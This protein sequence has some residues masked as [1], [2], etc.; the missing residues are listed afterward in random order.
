[1]PSSTAGYRGAL[2]AAPVLGDDRGS[3][4]L[5]DPFPSTAAGDAAVKREDGILRAV[6]ALMSLLGGPLVSYGL[7]KIAS[8]A[9]VSLST[10][11]FIWPLILFTPS[12]LGLLGCVAVLNEGNARRRVVIVG[13]ALIVVAMVPLYFMAILAGA[14]MGPG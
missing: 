13:G 10:A 3:K 5:V 14:R 9:G 11:V 8:E 2:G 4:D 6:L 7:F 1:M 12:M